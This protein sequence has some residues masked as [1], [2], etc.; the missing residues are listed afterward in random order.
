[1]TAPSTLRPAGPPAG[2]ASRV[3]TGVALLALTCV[4]GCESSAAVAP[5]EVP[6]F[7]ASR[8]WSDLVRIV[9]LGPRPVGSDA[10]E[11]Q[12]KLIEAELSRVGLT[13]VRETFRAQTPKGEFEMTNVYADLA[14]SAPEAPIV[15]L[16]S[17]IDTKL[18]EERFV[19]AN[20]GGSSTAVLLE[21]ARAV[22][23]SS[24]RPVTYR[25]LFLDG[26]EALRLD[27]RGE[28][29]TYGSRHHAKELSQSPIF[30]RVKAFVL[31]DL[32]G[33]RDLKL[34]RDSYSDRT[35][36]KIFTDA[37]RQNGL[38]QH[39]GGR[40]EPVKDDHLS[41]MR[42]GIPSVDL[43]DLDYGPN[44]SFWH[45][46]EDTLDKCSQES[47]DAIGRIVLHGLPALEA[48]ALAQN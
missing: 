15:I 36:M 5:P 13:P 24:P 42:V 48:W 27:W 43:I 4:A 29:N 7:D 21:L 9:E 22:T 12:R 38:G 25:F 3:L 47:L 35:L 18:L 16:G 41:F 31:L 14:A 46:P 30:P 26:E 6:P 1:M 33:D 44:N 19:G 8:A 23:A 32:V 11:S 39:V 10:L 2:A 17:H 28:D 20:D 45:T 37:A 40:S 34:T